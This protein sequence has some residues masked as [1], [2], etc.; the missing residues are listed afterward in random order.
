MAGANAVANT[1]ITQS[2]HWMSEM[3]QRKIGKVGT[4]DKARAVRCLS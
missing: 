4:S 1:R 3:E 2:P